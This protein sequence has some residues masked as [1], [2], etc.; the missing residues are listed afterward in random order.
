MC[1]SDLSSTICIAIL[2]DR[3][4]IYTILISIANK[5]IELPWKINSNLQITNESEVLN[6]AMNISIPFE[7]Q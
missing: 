3:S 7:K 6:G 2:T 4:P 1:H 5:K